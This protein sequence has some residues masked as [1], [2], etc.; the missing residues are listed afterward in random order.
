MQSKIRFKSSEKGMLLM[1]FFLF[2]FCAGNAQEQNFTQSFEERKALFSYENTDFD[3]RETGSEK[4]GTVTI[5]DI[6][7]TARPGNDPVRAYLVIPEGS[8]PF[9]GILWGHWLGH[10]TSDRDQYLDEA[11]ELASKGVVS[12]LINTMWSKPGWYEN[13]VLEEDYENSIRQVVEFN[14]AMDLL[15]AQQ[16]VDK[17]R[18]AYI[19]H[20][21]SGMYGS[22][23]AGVNPRARTYVFVAVTSSLY[24]WAFFA[25]QPKSKPEYVRQNAVFELTD[26]VSRIKGSVFCQFSSKDP[27]I[28]ITDGNVFYNAINSEVKEKKRYDAEHFMKGEDIVLD[29][30][31]WLI[32]ELELKK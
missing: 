1:L 22:I 5:R 31:A 29:R 8:G 30:K 24:D 19:G 9:A 17:E 13:R 23:A 2:V 20:D 4:R 32:R 18:I 15:I 28:S 27:Y 6:T 11:V 25:N 14:R 10:H 21:Y 26:Y 7:F 12:L 3:V 16:N